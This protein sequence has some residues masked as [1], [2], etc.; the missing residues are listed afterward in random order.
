MRTQKLVAL[1][2]V[3]LVFGACSSGGSSTTNTP[4][5]APA[6]A[7]AAGASTGAVASSAG[8]TVVSTEILV[9]VINS[10]IPPANI[11]VWVIG[12]SV[13]R[14]L[15]GD[16]AINQTKAFTFKAGNLNG[17]YRLVAQ[18]NGGAEIPSQP[19]NLTPTLRFVQWSLD[20]N[21]IVQ[22]QTPK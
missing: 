10:R 15:L 16:V 14:I 2:A 13:G 7:P 4:A 17:S 18:G 9:N 1:S 22:Y 8:D 11:T 6:A 3:A 20:V 21:S 5:P 19:F 12:P